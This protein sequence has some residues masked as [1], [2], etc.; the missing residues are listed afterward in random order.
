MGLS[1]A[2]LR[3]H[4]EDELPEFTSVWNDDPDDIKYPVS[5]SGSL[6]C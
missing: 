2:L 4:P 6:L 5:I 3:R 1:A